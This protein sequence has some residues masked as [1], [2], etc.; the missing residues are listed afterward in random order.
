MAFENRHRR[1]AD[2]VLEE[3]KNLIVRGTLPPNTRLSEVELSKRLGVSRTPVRES[4][5]RLAEDG[6]VN[7]FPQIGSFV[8]PISIE[9]VQQAQF[10]REHL[11]CAVVVDLAKCIDNNILRR[12][13]LNLSQQAEAARDNDWDAFYSLDEELHSTFAASCGHPGVWRVI[14]Q[15]KTQL[16]RVRHVGDCRPEHVGRLVTQHTAIVDAIAQGNAVEAQDLMRTHLREVLTTMLE[17]GIAK[18]G[19]VSIPRVDGA[20]PEP[21]DGLLDT[22]PH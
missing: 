18:G 14:Q 5:I 3:I 21:V 17:F 4:F 15:S 16:D 11:E 6:L 13:R 8:A 10:I 1:L 20:P 22:N 12:L 2:Q 19:E 9:A 7:V